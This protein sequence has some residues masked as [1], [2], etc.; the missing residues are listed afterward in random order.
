MRRTKLEKSIL[1]LDEDNAGLSV[2][3]ESMAKHMSPPKIR[4]FSVGVRPG[5]IPHEVR[6]VLQEIGVEQ[7]GSTT[8]SI[9]QD[10]TNDIGFVVSFAIAHDLFHSFPLK[11]KVEIWPIPK[12]MGASGERSADHTAYCRG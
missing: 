10:L 9:D 2:M 6:R 12:S 5:K 3:A 11:A 8:K 7:S 4:I 1:F